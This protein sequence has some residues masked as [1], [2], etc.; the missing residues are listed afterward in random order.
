[1]YRMVSGDVRLGLRN[2]LMVMRQ[3]VWFDFLQ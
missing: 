2:V 3:L 1:M